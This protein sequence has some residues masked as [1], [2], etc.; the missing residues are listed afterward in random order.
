MEQFECY[1]YKA[2][3]MALVAGADAI[4]SW[5][6][7]TVILSLASSSAYLLS[8]GDQRPIPWGDDEAIPPLSTECAAF[9]VRVASMNLILELTVE[10]H[11]WQMV[12]GGA[13]TLDAELAVVDMLRLLCLL[14]NVWGWIGFITLLCTQNAFPIDSVSFKI[15]LFGVFS[16]APLMIYSL[17]A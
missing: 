12:I 14:V 7:L 11:L 4:R 13:S 1:F 16:G 10:L 6:I 3:T 9:V 2:Y 17:S 8:Y 5:Q 15:I